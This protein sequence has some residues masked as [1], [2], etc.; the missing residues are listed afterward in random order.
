MYKQKE[1]IVEMP[2]VEPGSENKTT[3]TPTFIFYILRFTGNS[4]IDKV[5]TSYA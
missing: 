1:K 2:G 5:V 3:K 4:P